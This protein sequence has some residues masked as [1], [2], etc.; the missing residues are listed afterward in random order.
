MMTVDE[1]LPVMEGAF[2]SE[3]SLHLNDGRTLTKRVVEARGHPTR[4]LR[5]E[6]LARKFKGCAEDVLSSDQIDTVLDLFMKLPQLPKAT[7]L[8]HALASEGTSP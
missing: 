6:E 3:V 1:S 5:A 8:A 2:P 7:Q 4:P